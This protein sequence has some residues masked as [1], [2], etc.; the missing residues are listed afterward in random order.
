[1]AYA[2][3]EDVRKRYTQDFDET[4]CEALLEDAGIIIDSTN[5]LASEDT[6]R[7]VSVRM[8]MRALPNGQ[9]VPIGATQG[10][11]SALGYSQSWTVGSGSS[12]ELYLN[13]Q[14]RKLLGLGNKLGAHSPLEDL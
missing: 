12:G 5:T 14:E 10:T 1:M 8:V 11:I 6:K 7:V 9:D 2:K 4:V 13:K 3:V